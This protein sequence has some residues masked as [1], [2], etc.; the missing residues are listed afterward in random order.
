MFEQLFQAYEQRLPAELEEK[1]DREGW[2]DPVEVPPNAC[3][4]AQQLQLSYHQTPQVRVA[5]RCR[6][7]I[8]PKAALLSLLPA[9]EPLQASV[10][11]R[12]CAS[13]PAHHE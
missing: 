3:P 2:L 6:R 11:A 10:Y 9:T 5:L 1:A 13:I 7:H 4:A 12:H 8:L